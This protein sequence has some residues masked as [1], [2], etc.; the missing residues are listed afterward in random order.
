[1]QSVGKTDLLSNRFHSEQSRESVVLP[2]TCRPSPSIITIAFRS[3]N[4][5]PLLLD[6]YS[7]GGSGPSGMFPLLLRELLMFWPL[8]LV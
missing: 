5:R 6:L 2:F 7:Y 8:V 4:V 1:M 3:I